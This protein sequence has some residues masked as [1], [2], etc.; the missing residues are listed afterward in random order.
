MEY[1]HYLNRKKL[2]DKPTGLKTI[3]PLNDKLFP[4]QRDIVSWAL[5]R[6]RSAVFAGTGLGK[7]LMELSWAHAI[8]TEAGGD[9]LIITPLAVAAQM[10]KEGEKF[11]IT[12]RKCISQSEVT[13]GITVTLSLIHI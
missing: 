3:P 10:A 12:I 4:F 5:R 6:G 9:V 13:P 1:A 7:S 11:G 8:H 2:I